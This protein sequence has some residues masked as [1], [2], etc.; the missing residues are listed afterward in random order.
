M[1]YF[2][3]YL[4]AHES[5]QEIHNLYTPTD[6]RFIYTEREFVLLPNIG[7]IGTFLLYM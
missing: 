5:F 3:C 2:Q 6:W 7:Y 4:S 1:G